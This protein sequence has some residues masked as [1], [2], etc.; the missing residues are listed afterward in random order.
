MRAEDVPLA[1]EIGERMRK[2]RR[3]VFG[4][5]A[6]QAAFAR[7]MPSTVQSDI[8]RWERGERA[9]SLVEFIRFAKACGV[10][11]EKI[12]AEIAPPRAEQLQLISLDGVN[13]P[14][15]KVVRRLVDI[16]RERSQRVNGGRRRAS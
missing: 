14:A 7:L 12:I 16:L 2:T 3:Q 8:S 5:K 1:R 13:P 10:A 11:P 9:P 4:Q 15:A 6:S